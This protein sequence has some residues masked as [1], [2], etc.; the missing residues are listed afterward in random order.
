VDLAWKNRKMDQQKGG[1]RWIRN[2]LLEVKARQCREI[3]SCNTVNGLE[4]F[5]MIVR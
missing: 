5:P 2:L 4:R 3:T 1:Y